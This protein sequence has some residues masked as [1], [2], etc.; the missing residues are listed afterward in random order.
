[1]VSTGQLNTGACNNKHA[2]TGL[3]QCKECKRPRVH[4][5]AFV[6]TGSLHRYFNGKL[7]TDFR[8]EL[9]CDGGL[10][11]FLPSPRG[12]THSVRVCCFPKKQVRMVMT[13]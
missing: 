1:M 8:G 12:V 4:E 6:H 2:C 5:H 7:T 9:H 13:V 3:H 10:T 11:N